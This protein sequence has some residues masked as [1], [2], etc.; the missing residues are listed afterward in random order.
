MGVTNTEEIAVAMDL[1]AGSY[2]VRA[3]E[4]VQVIDSTGKEA[5]ACRWQSS[6][7]GNVVAELGMLEYAKQELIL[8]RWSLVEEVEEGEGE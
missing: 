3:I 5:I 6:G 8:Q 1:P 2:V 7:S 4:V